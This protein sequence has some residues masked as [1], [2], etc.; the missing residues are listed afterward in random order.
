[1]AKKRLRHLTGKWKLVHY[2]S[3]E[4]RQALQEIE[5]RFNHCNDTLSNP[6]TRARGRGVEYSAEIGSEKWHSVIGRVTACVRDVACRTVMGAEAL[7]LRA[8]LPIL[9]HAQTLPVLC[10]PRRKVVWASVVY[11]LWSTLVS[12]THLQKQ[13]ISCGTCLRSS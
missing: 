3:V 4:R 10:T 7:T 11:R 2:S 5:F 6:A 9:W 8:A 1:M 13:A 12:R